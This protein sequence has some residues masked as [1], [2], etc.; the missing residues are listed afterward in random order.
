MVPSL[1]S[2]L[3]AGENDKINYETLSFGA[4]GDNCSDQFSSHP[5]P[6]PSVDSRLLRLHTC[7]R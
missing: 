6:L 4:M 5:T 1:T 7:S 3:V 2:E